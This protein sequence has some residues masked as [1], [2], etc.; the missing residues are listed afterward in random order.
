MGYCVLHLEK[1]KGADSGM[2]AHIERNIPYPFVFFRCC[3]YLVFVALMSL[4]TVGGQSLKGGK[5]S[6]RLAR[7]FMPT[8]SAGVSRGVQPRCLLGD[9]QR[10]RSE[11]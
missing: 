3:H 1:A 4:D 7:F 5:T 2:S 6:F 8:G 10:T 11:A 9:F